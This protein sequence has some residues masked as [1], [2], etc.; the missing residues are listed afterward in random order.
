MIGSRLRGLLLHGE[1]R[2]R[3]FSSLDQDPDR[4]PTWWGLR[5]AEARRKRISLA[6]GEVHCMALLQ[7]A[8]LITRIWMTVLP[9]LNRGVLRNVVLRF[10]WDGEATPS[11]ECPLGDFFGAPFGRSVPFVAEPMSI[12]GGGF[13]CAWPMPYAAGAR[14]EI[15]NE[16]ASPVDPLFYQITLLELTGP[17][18]EL[19]FHAHWRRENPTSAGTSYTILKAE[20]SGH[21]VGCFVFLQNR[22][23]WLRPSVRAAFPYGF[24][25]GMLEGRE[26]IRVDGEDVP[27]IEGTGTEDYFNGGWYFR[28]GTFSA[29]THGCTMRDFISGRVSAY[30]F[31]L[32]APL[33]FRRSVEITLDHGIDNSLIC[34]YASVA[35]WYQEEPHPTFAPLPDVRA[36]RPRSPVASRIQAATIILGALAL[37]AL[38]LVA[39]LH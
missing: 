19:R 35:Y 15:C 1:G 36:R 31:D 14:L 3:Q 18:T 27:S 24:G 28:G 21:Y 20:G 7:G 5:P 26:H 29:P 33:P 6:P 4:G 38:A 12:A 25:L 37:G 32:D 39:L 9:Q 23:W 8:G 11:V 34:D 17:G 10:Y 2:M 22:E 16:G 13:Y 30:R